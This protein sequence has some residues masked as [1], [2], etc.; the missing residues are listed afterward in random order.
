LSTDAILFFNLNKYD[1]DNSCTSVKKSVTK[2][3]K[4]LH[5]NMHNHHTGV[6]E[7]YDYKKYS[8]VSGGMT[9]LLGHENL[10]IHLKVV[11]RGIHAACINLSNLFSFMKSGY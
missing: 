4:L 2:A 9:F 8:V 10:L 5:C 11:R 7:T 3:W 1:T 6:A